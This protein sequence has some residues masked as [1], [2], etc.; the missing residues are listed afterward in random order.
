VHVLEHMNVTRDEALP[1]ARRVGELA[2]SR[3]RPRET[4]VLHM[5]LAE[6]DD[7]PTVAP[8]SLLWA[9]HQHVFA[10]VTWQE[11]KERYYQQIYFEGVTPVQLASGMKSGRDY[12]S[13]IALFGW[14]RHTDRLN[15]AYRPLT[16][17]EIDHETSLYNEYI[18][19][20]D[21]RSA[22]AHPIDYVIARVDDEEAFQMVDRWY[23]RDAGEIWG[24]YVLHKLTMR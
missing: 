15:A 18:L 13:T 23:V 5:G 21:P 20:Y 19:R 14:G 22:S 3:G 24:P 12:V 17:G 10:G 4:T 6:A 8:V 11:N 2:R 7:L 1:V 16:F 9:R